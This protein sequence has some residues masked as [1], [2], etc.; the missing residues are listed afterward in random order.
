MVE[1]QMYFKLFSIFVELEQ[2]SNFLNTAKLYPDFEVKLIE[3][4]LVN[5]SINRNISSLYDF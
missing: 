1:Q 4:M 3:K 5:L 2:T